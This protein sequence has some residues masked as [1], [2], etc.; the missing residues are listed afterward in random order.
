MAAHTH[1]NAR[2][3]VHDMSPSSYRIRLCRWL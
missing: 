1:I 2:L 3:S